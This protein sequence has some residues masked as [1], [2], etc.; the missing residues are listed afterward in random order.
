MNDVMLKTI[1]LHFM[2]KNFSKKIG[3][4]LQKIRKLL[5]F[6]TTCVSESGFS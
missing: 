2:R 4:Q 1:I 3:A 5:P 6:P